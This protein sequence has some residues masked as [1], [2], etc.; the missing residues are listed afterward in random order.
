MN[1]MAQPGRAVAVAAKMFGIRS[2][3]GPRTGMPA[4]WAGLLVAAPGAAPTLY[5]PAEQNPAEQNPAER[6]HAAKML[7]NR[8]FKP[9][10]GD[11]DENGTFSCA[12]ELDTTPE[13]AR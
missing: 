9:E 4:G 12:V 7:V 2:V 10:P 6:D 3:E 13:D 5:L 1:R 11:V 8:L